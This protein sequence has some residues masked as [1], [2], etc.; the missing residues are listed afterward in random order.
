MTDVCTCISEIW[1]LVP[2]FT[3]QVTNCVNLMN[4]CFNVKENSSVRRMMN[5]NSIILRSPVQ[6]NV[7]GQNNIQVV[8]LPEWEWVFL[9]GGK[10]SLVIFIYISLP[11]EHCSSLWG[12]E[13]FFKT[14]SSVAGLGDLASVSMRPSM[15]YKTSKLHLLLK[16]Y[17]TSGL[18]LRKQ[19]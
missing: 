4:M 3:G 8:E 15:R 1:I 10:I 5:T 16:L 11:W 14:G 9:E 7:V 12:Q 17:E 19:H 2:A 13:I 6:C 18:L